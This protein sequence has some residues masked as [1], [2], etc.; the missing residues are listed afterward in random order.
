MPQVDWAR[1]WMVQAKVE[2]LV[3]MRLAVDLFVDL[4]EGAEV[5]P[6]VMWPGKVRSGWQRG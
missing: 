1:I 5:A 2:R 3:I 4:E 6:V